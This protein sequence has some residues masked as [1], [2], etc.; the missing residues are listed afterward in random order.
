MTA[1]PTRAPGRDGVRDAV[2]AALHRFLEDKEEADPQARLHGFT[3]LL[4]AM[5]AAGG[6]R[7]RPVLCCAGWQAAGGGDPAPAVPAAASLELFHMFAL[8]H[9]DVMD[10]S[11]TRRGRPTARRVLAARAATLPAV[12]DAGEATRFGDSGAVLLGDLAMVWSDELLHSGTLAPARLRAAR[13]VLEAM[14]SEVMY[15]QYLD[16]FTSKDPDAGLESALTV[17]RYKTAKYTVERPLQ[18]GA[19]LAGGDRRILEACSAYGL[20][21][22][23]AF[24]LRDDVLDVFGDPARTGKSR[25]G[26]L[27]EGKLTALL[28]TALLRAGPGQGRTLRTLVGDPELD[29]EGAAAVRRV[30][31]ETG[32]LEAVEHM[33]TKRYRRAVRSLDSAPFPPSAKATLRELATA[34]TARS[35]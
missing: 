12:R 32:A 20:P 19:A 10:R 13:P 15:G 4:R 23:E 1:P 28:A 30:F 9:D 14:R 33:I 8:I 17:V 25:L 29:E 35:A 7:L 34:A 16:L 18:L 31:R 24:Q 5:L 26:D 6:K 2:E 22:G 21:L 11:D 27:R 3:G